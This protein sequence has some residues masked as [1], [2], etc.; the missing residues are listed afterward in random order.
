MSH[1][2]TFIIVRGAAP[3]TPSAK[4]QCERQEM[5]TIEKWTFNAGYVADDL[6]SFLHIHNMPLV[7]IIKL[8]AKS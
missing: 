7:V 1:L 5:A 3:T 4:L 2:I 8:W 6:S